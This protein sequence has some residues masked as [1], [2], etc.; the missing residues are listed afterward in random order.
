MTFFVQDYSIHLQK[1]VSHYTL[2]TNY[3]RFF[4]F[5]SLQKVLRRSILL[6]RLYA[7]TENFNTPIMVGFLQEAIT[8]KIPF[9][10]KIRVKS[11]LK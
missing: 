6:E 8:M 7:L 10:R 11:R 9:L 2:N 3:S 5:V 4:L 1:L